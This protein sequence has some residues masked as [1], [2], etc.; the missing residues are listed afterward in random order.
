MWRQWHIRNMYIFRCY[1]GNCPEIIWW[2]LPQYNQNLPRP[3]AC[4]DVLYCRR[5]HR[6]GWPNFTGVSISWHHEPC[7]CL[8]TPLFYTSFA[9][10][11][12]FNLGPVWIHCV[13]RYILAS[14]ETE[15]IFHLSQVEDEWGLWER[16]LYKNAH[17][18]QQICVPVF[19]LERLLGDCSDLETSLERKK[20]LNLAHPHMN[21][22]RYVFQ[23]SS[24]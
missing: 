11:D 14:V 8:G 22:R 1:A 10:R 12:M 4:A 15:I 6:L 9:V 21:S 24:S 18:W 19:Q 7:S 13:G 2:R 20:W 16:C 17:E 23:Q 3:C 5:H